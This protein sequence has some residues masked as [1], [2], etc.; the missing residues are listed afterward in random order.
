ML[1][2]EADEERASLVEA[3]PATAPEPEPEREQEREGEL[4]R[5]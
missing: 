1:A 2:R 4:I 3:E 5:I